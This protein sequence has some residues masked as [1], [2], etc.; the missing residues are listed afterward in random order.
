MVAGNAS[1]AVAFNGE[2]YNY[3]E[4]KSEHNRSWTTTS[5]TE[6]LLAEYAT[7]GAGCVDRL[8]GMFAFAIWDN[9]KSLLLL[10]RDPLGEKPLYYALEGGCLYFASSLAALASTAR[11]KWSVNP[12]AIESYLAAGFVPAPETVYV[13]SRKLRAGT[14]L[15]CGPATPVTTSQYWHP[16]KVPYGFVGTF[17]DAVD[18]ARQLLRRS[19]ELQL[20]SDVPLGVF[21]SGGID[22]SLI[23][24][25]VRRESRVTPRTFSIGFAG[26]S[27][28]ETAYARTVADALQTEHHEFQVDSALIKYV[29]PLVANL[30]EPFADPATLPVWVLAEAT[31]QHVTVSLGGDGGDEAFGGYTWYRTAAKVEQAWSRMGGSTLRVPRRAV[32]AGLRTGLAGSAGRQL[33]RSLDALTPQTPGARYAGIRRL[34]SELDLERVI[35]KAAPSPKAVSQAE[36]AFDAG[37]GHALRRMQVVDIQGY[38]ADGLNLKLDVGTMAHALEA[39]SPLLDRSV[40]EFGLSLP[41]E[42]QIDEKGGKRILRSLLTHYLPKEIVDRPKHGFTLPVSEWFRSDRVLLDSLLESEAWDALPYVSRRGLQS[43]AREHRA[44]TRDHGDR[45]FALLTLERWARSL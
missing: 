40:V 39:R 20:R 43:I 35:P 5:D 33:G 8:R 31:R 21:L 23:A 13:E 45:L 25:I 27:H 32:A 4:L 11:S 42:L 18:R 15:L 37:G 6:V 34:F 12:S 7:R 38:L 16:A 30:G 14:V 19:V 9:A 24:A 44:H 2:I 10:A 41:E 22:S 28:D 26:T 17:D 1:M 3:V 29:D 36:E